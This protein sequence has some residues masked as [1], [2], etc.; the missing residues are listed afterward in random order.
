MCDFIFHILKKVGLLQ[1]KLTYFKATSL[2]VLIVFVTIKNHTAFFPISGL[3]AKIHKRA[4]EPGWAC[5]WKQILTQADDLGNSTNRLID[6]AFAD[7]DQTYFLFHPKWR[8]EKG[9][10][11]SLLEDEEMTSI[12]AAWSGLFTIGWFL[13]VWRGPGFHRQNYIGS[14]FLGAYRVAIGVIL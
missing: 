1:S 12:V 3:G 4:S 14:S 7:T 6:F 5:D 13:S 11:N 8:E 10:K 2:I 9:D